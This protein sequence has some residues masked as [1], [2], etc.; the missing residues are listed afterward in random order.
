M[1]CDEI[2]VHKRESK[3]KAMLPVSE[4]MLMLARTRL[5]EGKSWGWKDIDD[6]MTYLG[7]M[8]GFDQVARA[9]EYTSAETSAENHCVQLW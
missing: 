1:S 7:M 5:W 3:S 4:D 8:W 9:G 2:R 6:R